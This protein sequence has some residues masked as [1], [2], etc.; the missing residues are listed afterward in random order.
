MKKGE[1]NF[2][3]WNKRKKEISKK[4]AIPFFR[5]GEVWMVSFGEN[6]GSESCG[7]G[8]NFLRPVLILKVWNQYFFTGIP[9]T[10]KKKND[11]FHCSIGIIGE[12]ESFAM[13]SQVKQVDGRR[14][15]D[16]MGRI[17]KDKVLEIKKS[18]FDLL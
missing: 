10:S 16:K 8:D 18:L 9:L 14:L 13:L 11:K 3:D 5:Q 12:I 1:R 2:D 6:I 7:K 17:G 15:T 4:N